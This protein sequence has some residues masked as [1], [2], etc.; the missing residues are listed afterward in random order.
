MIDLEDHVAYSQMGDDSTTTVYAVELRAIKMALD[1][2]LNITK[3][4][5]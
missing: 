2:V 5:T 4:W 1:S 3:P